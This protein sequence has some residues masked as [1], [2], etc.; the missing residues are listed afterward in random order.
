MTCESCNQI[1][2][3]RT[4]TQKY[5]SKKCAKVGQNLRK[6]NRK[7][8]QRILTTESVSC[9]ICSREFIPSGTRTRC[10][11]DRCTNENK[12]IIKWFVNDRLNRL[13]QSKRSYDRYIRI[14]RK[15]H[16][17]PS[18]PTASLPTKTYILNCSNCGC[19]YEKQWKY[20]KSKGFSY[21]SPTCR[22]LRWQR[23][24]GNRA[25]GRARRIDKNM[26]ERIRKTVKNRRDASDWRDMVGYT[27]AELLEHLERQFINGMTWDNYGSVWH[28][29]H[30]KPLDHF[31]YKTSKNKQFRK[32]WALSNLM[33]RFATTA[34]AQ[35]HGSNQTGNIN[36]GNRWAG[37][38]YQPEL[39]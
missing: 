12:R 26:G 37:R 14:V 24:S 15:A 21:C 23:T 30:V 22:K 18:S 8:R 2:T 4:P 20:N 5:C 17:K 9:L 3:P 25:M 36:K 28:I 27:N 10:C 34:I 1:F 31:N 32:A 13:E 33:P 7:L 19:G 38:C 11:S 29:D 16:D 6:R 39:I 35:E